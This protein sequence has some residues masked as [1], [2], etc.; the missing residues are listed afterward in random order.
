[1]KVFISWSG[2]AEGVVA[3]A[4]REAL[5]AVSANG[6]QAFVSNVD[7]PRGE[8]GVA[9]IESELQATDYG[10]VILSAGNKDRPWINYEGGALATALGR[11]VATVLLNLRTADVDTPLAPFQATLFENRSSVLR[12]FTEIIQSANPAFPTSSIETLFDAA[13]PALEASWV[14]EASAGANRRPPNDMLE[15]VVNSVRRLVEGQAAIARSVADT[16]RVQQA[17][18]L[19]RVTT[20]ITNFE[21]YLRDRVRKESHGLVWVEAMTLSGTT[22]SVRLSGY[23]HTTR[24]EYEEAMEVV[25]GLTPPDNP[26]VVAA[27]LEP[28]DRDRGWLPRDTVRSIRDEGR[29]DEVSRP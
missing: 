24:A 4:L 20:P 13:W 7:I 19:A 6:V 18:R 23:D 28:V 14:P 26:A 8:R 12:L 25:W 9:A 16:S 21:D 3:E 11:R 27:P 22:W 2:Q 17:E 15:E 1:M 10:I 29:G 5:H